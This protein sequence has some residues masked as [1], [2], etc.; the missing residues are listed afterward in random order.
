MTTRI[1]TLVVVVVLAVA[2]TAQEPRPTFEVASVKPTPPGRGGAS[3]Y[4][5]QPEGYRMYG[6]S[7]TQL[8]QQAYGLAPYQVVG[9]PDWARRQAFTIEAK[10][11]EGWSLERSGYA[12]V[13]VSV[14]RRART[15]RTQARTVARTYRCARD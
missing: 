13:R 14:H 8:I 1:L 6:A 2:V 10:Y 5:P 3:L 7:L 9:E 15:A 12:E 11:P 4:G